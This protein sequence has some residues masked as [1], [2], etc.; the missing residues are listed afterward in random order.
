M[1]KTEAMY[2]SASSANAYQS[3]GDVIKLDDIYDELNSVDNEVHYEN[4][5]PK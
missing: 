1:E 4:I 3:M 5:N 2:Q